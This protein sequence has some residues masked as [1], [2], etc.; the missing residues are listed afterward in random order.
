MTLFFGESRAQSPHLCGRAIVP[1]LRR[2]SLQGLFTATT[3]HGVDLLRELLLSIYEEQLWARPQPEGRSRT[4]FV[5]ILRTCYQACESRAQ[6][7]HTVGELYQFASKCLR[8]KEWKEKFVCQGAA[9]CSENC[10]PFAVQESFVH[11]QT[12]APDFEKSLT[13]SLGGFAQVSAAGVHEQAVIDLDPAVPE[14]VPSFQV[15]LLG[16]TSD[17]VIDLD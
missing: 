8:E 4:S 5:S 1:A 16:S 13:A 11:A 15:P 17:F 3:A 12:E 2:C 7:L 10:I 9:I 14:Q 6:S